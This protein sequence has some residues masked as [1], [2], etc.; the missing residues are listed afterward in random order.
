[1]RQHLI[2]IAGLVLVFLTVGVLVYEKWFSHPSIK[3]DTVSSEHPRAVPPFATKEPDRYQATR[4]IT[5][6]ETATDSGSV[7]ETRTT[8]VNIS[9]DGVQRREEHQTSDSGS[10]IYLENTSGH[11]ILLPKLKLYANADGEA[12]GNGVSEHTVV[13]DESSPDLLLHESPAASLYLKLGPEN[14]S[15]RTTTKY[16]VS[17]SEATPGSETFV[18]VDE[19]F[20][21]PIK[22]ESTHRRSSFTTKTSMELKDIRLEVDPAWFLLPG[23]YRE[24]A[25]SELLAAIRRPNANTDQK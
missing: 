16:R 18:W 23:D 9:R 15:G 12:R 6:T 8:S 24:V 3:P 10:I 2:F 19:S 4:T 25:L 13:L 22:S 17:N 20:G 11:F 21:M 5:Y 14:V 1:M 7:N